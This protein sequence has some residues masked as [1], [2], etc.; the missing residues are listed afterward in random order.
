MPGYRATVERAVLIHLVGFDWNCQQHIT[1]RWSQDEL[2][3]TMEPVRRRV[4][5]LEAENAALRQQLHLSALPEPVDRSGITL[6][7]ANARAEDQG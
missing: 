2:T 4:A 6:E 7:E 3:E 5:E 1:P